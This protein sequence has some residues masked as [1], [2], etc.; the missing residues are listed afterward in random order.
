MTGTLLYFGP[1]GIGDWCFIYPSLAQLLAGCGC[2]RICA[3]VP[4]RN[5]GNQLLGRNPL[6]QE[7]RWLHRAT[8]PGLPGYGR[9]WLGLLRWIRRSGFRALATSYLSNQPDFLLLARLSGIPLRVGRPA[10]GPFGRGAFTHPVKTAPGQGKV[11]AHAAYGESFPATPVPAAPPLFGPE[12][13]TGQEATLHRLGLTVPYVVLGVGGGREAGWRFWPAGHFRDL[14]AANSQWRFV[15]L[16]GG[17][18]DRAQ[19]DAILQGAPSNTRDLVGS[20]T[21]EEA[22]H[23]LGGALAML[24]NDSG[25]ANIS[26]TLGLPTLGLYGPTDPALT[27]PA[28]L[29]AEALRIEVPCGPCFG[30]DQDPTTARACDHRRCLTG[31]SARQVSQALQRMLR[32]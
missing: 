17:A 18:D 21:M 22:L 27:G 6:F 15:L 31:L 14:M 8:G 24:G 25:L 26:A 20:V 13:F 30:D 11:V 28:L 29:D 3:V 4:Y 2:E 9:R 19:A 7:L 12:L 23:V 1:S 32:P 10:P 5:P 16:G